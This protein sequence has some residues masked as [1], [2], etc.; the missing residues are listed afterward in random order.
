MIVESE[1]NLKL[2]LNTRVFAIEKQGDKIVSVT[3]RN[4]ETGHE[5]T[6]RGTLY[7]DCTGDANLGYLA[8]A[9]YREG[10]ESKAET[11]ETRSPEV[12][13][14]QVMSTS[15]QWYA[16]EKGFAVPFPECPW[17]VSFTDETC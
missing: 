10:R 13:D 11:G 2:F 7:A 17:A 9:D 4:I 8:G 6:L 12:S 16:Q 15:V 1:P 5:I 3:G 14:N